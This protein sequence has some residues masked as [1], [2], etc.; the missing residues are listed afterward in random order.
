MKIKI[1]VA[2]VVSL[3]FI[4]STPPCSA[5]D[6]FHRERLIR[7]VGTAEINVP[8]DEV[9]LSLSVESHDKVL[10][11]A[12][13]QNDERVKNILL[14]AREAGVGQVDIKTSNLR[15]NPDYS[16]DNV[17]RFLG[18]EVSQTIGIT[19]K[20]LSKY[21]TLMTQTLEAGA[22]RVN[23]VSFQVAE[24]RKFRDEAR[25]KAVTA[26][27]E[28]ATAMAAVLGQTIGKPWEI[29]EQSDSAINSNYISPMQNSVSS[30]GAPVEES[31]VAP[32]QVSI[33]ATVWVSFQLE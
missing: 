4:T 23:S 14:L 26:A 5:Q 12:K 2:I 16:Y 32:G 33:T 22:N 28:K 20:D 10:A 15:M 21:E 25:A 6:P 31:T 29:S 18:Y 24:P 7:V 27:K 17:P 30:R 8:P 19:L 11:V 1:F 3:L 13:K 9:V